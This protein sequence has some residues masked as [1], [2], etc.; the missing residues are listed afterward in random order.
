MQFAVVIVIM[1]EGFIVSVIGDY[2]EDHCSL[3]QSHY[4]H[5]YEG[6]GYL[7]AKSEPCLQLGL[8]S[9]FI[10]KLRQRERFIGYVFGKRF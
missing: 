5:H 10:E 6:S 1:I 7:G 3:V 4:H 9:F 2:T 8:G